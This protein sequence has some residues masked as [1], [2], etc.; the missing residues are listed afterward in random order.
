MSIEYEQGKDWKF[1][2]NGDAR[3]ESF[4][5]NFFKAWVWSRES[6]NNERRRVVREG[7]LEKHLEERGRLR[8]EG[9]WSLVLGFSFIVGLNVNWTSSIRSGSIILRF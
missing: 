3:V 9:L 7:Q 5:D 6:K 8:L 4:G 2:S 1:G